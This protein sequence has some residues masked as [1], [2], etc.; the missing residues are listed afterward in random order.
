MRNQY[1]TKEESAAILQTINTL[2][3]VIQV[4]HEL[5][6]IER[7]YCQEVRDKLNTIILSPPFFQED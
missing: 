7:M 2:S 6:P 1:V 3:R 4:P 5:S